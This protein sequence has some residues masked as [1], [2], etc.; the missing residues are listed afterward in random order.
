MDGEDLADVKQL[1]E[2]EQ[3]KCPVSGSM[4]WT[5][6]RQFNLM[7]DTQMGSVAEGASTL[8]LRPGDG[9]RYLFELPQRS[10]R[11]NENSRYRT[12]RERL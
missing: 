8:Y 12:D 6:V 1:I 5:N 10:N 2:D 3:I 9:A 7:F 4:N 11:K